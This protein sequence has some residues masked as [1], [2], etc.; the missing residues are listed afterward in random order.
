[1]RTSDEFLERILER[2]YAGIHETAKDN[3]DALR[4]SWDG[5]DRS[6]KFKAAQHR[7][8]L[9][10]VAK[11]HA[12]LFETWRLLEDERSK[13]L[14]LELILYRL[15]GHLHVKLSTN[16]PRYW[17]HVEAMKR[18]SGTPSRLACDGMFGRLR[19]YED[20]PSAGRTLRLDCLD[21]DILATF[22]LRQYEFERDGVRI[23]AEEGDHVVDAGACFGDGAAAFATAVGPRGRVY[24][25]EVLSA[26]QAVLRHNAAQ[27]PDLQPR[28]TLFACA[29]GGSSN[30]VPEQGLGSPEQYNPGFNLQSMVGGVFPVR[31]LDDLVAGGAIP[32]VDFVKMDIEGFELEALQGARRTLE[33]FRP[34]LAVSLYHRPSD[35]V[36]I[37]RL[38]AD[39][40]YRLHLDHHT[41]HAEETVLYAAPR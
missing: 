17:E 34:R 19:H 20:L 27:N 41:I 22:L 3:Y 39:L 10:F 24:S 31:C 15:L 33:R 23:R 9:A 35:F 14:F 30:D 38:L 11:E 2:F 5:V 28:L 25:F 6:R 1:M 18:L 40:G 21:T 26:H 29:L 7:A 32:R 37:P 16:S 13:E 12:G 36:T 4:F 8:Y